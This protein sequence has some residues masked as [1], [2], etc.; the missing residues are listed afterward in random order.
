MLCESR[1]ALCGVL[2][3][4]ASQPSDTE[5]PLCH[6]HH[7]TAWSQETLLQ[8]RK[9][10]FSLTLRSD[11]RIDIKL[12]CLKIEGLHKWLTL[13]ILQKVPNHFFCTHTHTHTQIQ[14]LSLTEQ[15]EFTELKAAQT[16]SRAHF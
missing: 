16:D 8:K 4:A 12:G 11:S 15:S 6:H 2:L 9:T 14:L 3:S 7:H 1:S 5:D 10:H 13:L